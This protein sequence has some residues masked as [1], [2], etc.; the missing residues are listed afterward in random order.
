[1]SKEATPM[2]N[3]IAIIKGRTLKYRIRRNS[4]ARKLRVSVCREQGVVV[5]LPTRVALSEINKSFAKWEDWLERNINQTN[6]WNGPLIREYANGS[7]IYFMGVAHKMEISVL[8]EGKTRSR[9]DLDA[10]ILKME[11]LPQDVLSP[12]PALVKFLR[13]KA[14]EDFLSRVQHWSTVT[15]LFPSRIVV[16]ERTTRWGSCSARGTLSFCY[17]LILAPPQVI[18][19]IVIHELCHLKHMNH[20]KKFWALVKHHNPGHL[21]TSEWLSDNWAGLQ[22]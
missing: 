15:G 3:G 5:T 8:P 10:G 21:E 13:K 1:M 11:L 4:R 16:G 18:D 17:R 22:V 6:A 2:K 19:A 14:K 20:G 7:T 9:V 12:R